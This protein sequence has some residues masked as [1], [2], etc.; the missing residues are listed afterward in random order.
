MLWNR[1][2]FVSCSLLLFLNNFANGM[3]RPA[4]APS[5]PETVSNLIRF[6]HIENQSLFI[7]DGTAVVNAMKTPFFDLKYLG[8]L[9]FDNE[10]MP[11]FLLSG[12]P[13]E[14][15]MED[16]MIYAL[17]PK[18]DKQPE[19]M[20]GFVYPGKIFDP[21]T[22][23]LLYESRGFFGKCLSHRENIYVV[24]QKERIDRKRHLQNSVFIAEAADHHLEEVLLE[25]NLPS[26]NDTLHRVKKKSCQEISGRNRLMLSKPLDLHP[27]STA[28]L[29]KEEDDET[30][31]Q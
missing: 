15:C 12:R 5:Q 14:N 7:Q 9:R 8:I 26:I 16:Q 23:S 28:D 31:I 11:Y 4:L 19:S 22:R 25:R 10:K 20:S 2:L 24:F 21:R 29:E 6:D 18:Y 17:R 27:H 13:C 1:Q 3:Q 30:V